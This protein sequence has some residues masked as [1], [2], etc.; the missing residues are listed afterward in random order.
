MLEHSEALH[1][2]PI[3]QPR[4]PSEIGGNLGDRE[5]FPALTRCSPAACGSIIDLDNGMARFPIG[6]IETNL[7]AKPDL[8]VLPIEKEHNHPGS[9]QGQLLPPPSSA[10]RWAI[11]WSGLGCF[12][13]IC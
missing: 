4:Q 3:H 10:F 1:S 13:P 5:S 6:E 2:F 8:N 12:R 9:R 7:L 11:S